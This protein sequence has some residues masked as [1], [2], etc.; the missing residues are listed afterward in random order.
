MISS[1]TPASARLR[2]APKSSA[3]TPPAAQHHR[4]DRGEGA[5]LHDRQPDAEA[6]HP[7]ALQQRRGA[8]H[9]QVGA[10]EIADVRDGHPQRRAD[11]Q[12]HRHGTRV[13]GE[14]VL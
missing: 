4:G 2:G 7:E 10:D 12:R 6:P 1:T 13:H 3:P 8:G 9:Q 5:A 14:H 11:D